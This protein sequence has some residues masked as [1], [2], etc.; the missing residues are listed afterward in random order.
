METP[1][2]RST[3]SIGDNVNSPS[4]YQIT[5]EMEVIDLIDRLIEINDEALTKKQSG[6]YF[7]TMKYLC[8]FGGKN[9]LEDLKKARY[10]LNRMITDK[11]SEVSN[12]N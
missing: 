2:E 12:G 4:H 11:E 1:T 3:K 10:Y 8:R 5:E 6:Y 7:N 9:G